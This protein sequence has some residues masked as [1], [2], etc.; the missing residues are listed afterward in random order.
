MY[1]P[2][3]G[4]GQGESNTEPYV[5]QMT[6]SGLSTGHDHAWL[7]MQDIF[8]LFHLDR[9]FKFISKTSNFYIPIVGWSM[10]MTGEASSCSAGCHGAEPAALHG[11]M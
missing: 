9:S 8:S 10:F 1:L 6:V 2:A 5:C 11:C 7:A 3:A 4:H